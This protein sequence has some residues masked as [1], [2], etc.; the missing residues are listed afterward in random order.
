MKPGLIRQKKFQSESS[1][2]ICFFFLR[3]F[4]GLSSC[5]S[6]PSS[7]STLVAVVVALFGTS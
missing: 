2:G 3:R 5:F 7:F 6:S 4:W 1:L